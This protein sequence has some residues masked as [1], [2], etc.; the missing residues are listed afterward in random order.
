MGKQQTPVPSLIL[1]ADHATVM[2]LQGLPDYQPLNPDYHTGQLL[3]LQANLVQTEQIEQ[4]AEAA[5]AQ[6]RSARV[7]ATHVY[8]NAVVGARTHVIAQYGPDATA[9]SLVGLTRKSQR[10]R[11]V[12]RSS[13]AQ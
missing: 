11:P 6:A 2:A 7:Q 4:A 8:H 5:L 9:V 12:K 13:V 1:A 10:K 3:Q